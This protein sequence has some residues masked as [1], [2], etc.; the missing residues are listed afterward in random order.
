MFVQARMQ[1]QCRLCKCKHKVDACHRDCVPVPSADGVSH[2][3]ILLRCQFGYSLLFGKQ[4]VSHCPSPAGR[5]DL[6][7]SALRQHTQLVV[8]LQHEQS[9]TQ[10]CP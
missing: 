5:A 7:W 3:W 1:L 8:R 4:L 2:L 6:T 10:H 9:S